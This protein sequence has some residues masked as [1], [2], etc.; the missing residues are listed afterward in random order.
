MGTTAVYSQG[1]RVD[2]R[3]AINSLRYPRAIMRLIGAPG[4]N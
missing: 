3:R 4:D 2:L 1:K